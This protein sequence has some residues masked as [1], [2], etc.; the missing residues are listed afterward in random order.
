MQDETLAADIAAVQHAR[1]YFGHQSVGNNILA[2]ISQLY[3][4]TPGAPAFTA[5]HETDV[6]P[7]SYFAEERI[8]ENTHP[9]LKCSAFVRALD[10]FANRPPDVALMKFCY[11]DFGAGKSA[12]EI[13]ALYESTI[14]TLR[15]KFP[16]V[17]FIH[18]TAPLTSRRTDL[19]GVIRRLLGRDSF[20][21]DNAER[22]R[23]NQ[24]LAR[25]FSDEPIFDLARIESTRP[26]GTR[27]EFSFNGRTCDAL[28]PEYT[29]D[30]GHLNETARELAARELLRVLAQTIRH[31]KEKSSLA[32]LKK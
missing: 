3:A 21:S 5:W 23:F 20:E 19:K 32:L 1:V 25:R 31:Q 24:L 4:R 12:E 27:E 8:G 10:R 30:G 7:E 22:S 14:D 9:D 6:L 26:D 16:R 15:K 17:T 28:V 29:D 13:F 2:G 18:V 11:V